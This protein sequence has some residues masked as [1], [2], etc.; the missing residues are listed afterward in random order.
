MALADINSDPAMKQYYDFLTKIDQRIVDQ[1][2]ADSAIWFPGRA[3]TQETLQLAYYPSF[4]PGTKTTNKEGKPVEY[5]PL[6][7]FKI[8]TVRETGEVDVNVYDKD[9]NMLEPESVRPGAKVV[10]IGELRMI[11]FVGAQYG[12]TWLARQIKVIDAPQTGSLP[13][14]AFLD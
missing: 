3:W 9:G 1:A 10:T 8:N 4:K 11:W 7:K 5:P 13:D 12:L 14:F 2:F 6:T